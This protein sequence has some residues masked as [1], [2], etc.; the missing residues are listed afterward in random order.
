[1]DDIEIKVE[2]TK[3]EI[4]QYV[5]DSLD[6]TIPQ[7]KHMIWAMNRFV[8]DL[9]KTKELDSEY[10][11]DWMEVYKF[12]EWARLF[13]HS[14]GV[15]A[16]KPIE[17]HVSV[18][19]ECANIFGFKQR[20]NNLRRFKEAN[21]LKARK[22]MK[23]QSNS[24][25]AS[26]I[27][28]LS[29]AQEE[30]YVAGWSREQSDI[31]YR[32]MVGQI[33][34]SPF[35]R[36]KFK[37]TYGYVTVFKNGST[38]K[39]LSRE[40]KRF[41]DGTSPSLAIIDEYSNSHMTNEIVDVLQSGMVARPEPLTVFISTTGFNLE[42][43]A[44]KYYQYCSSILNPESD[45][46]NDEIFVAIYQL[47]EGDDIKDESV[48]RK[49]NPLVATY[50]VGINYLRSELKKA[51]DQPEK[52]RNFLTKNMNMWV[53]QKDDGFISLKKWNTQEYKDDIE[54]FM[55]GANVYLGVDLS[56]TTDLTSVG[57]VAVKEG[58]FLVGQ[59]SFMPADKF[60]ERM[61]RDK[62]RFDLYLDNGE[63]TLTEGSVVDYAYVKEHIL[64]FCQK[65]NVK[66]IGFDMWNAT[67]LATELVNEGLDIVEISQSIAK[68]SEPTKGFREKLYQ[69]ILYHTG[70]KLL[71][72]AVN[73]AI[74]M[75]DPNENLKLNKAKSKDR[76]DPIASII[77]AFSRAM[78]DDQVLDINEVVLSGSWSF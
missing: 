3:Q 38:V 55:S 5:S 64:N 39:S 78:F 6:G 11:F 68:L 46:T 8:S 37:E 71:K 18:L 14:K 32:E 42:Y 34:G 19:W 70:D 72:W 54:E 15:L 69:G 23:T 12:K 49:S 10:I 56:S 74:V 65:Y 7:G 66:E 13:K 21:I 59:H 52:M 25:I 50:D 17:L 53:D 48:W 22:N 76:I 35:L 27:A 1:M 73:N 24:L 75:T 9:E 47:D 16:G 26:Y 4:M 41:G 40:A 33:E 2:E 43:P 60:R 36:D 57:W 30:V 77:N 61:S 20:E 28:F 31:C 51:L 44:Y 45:V 63:L 29:D 58:K 67:Y 62:I